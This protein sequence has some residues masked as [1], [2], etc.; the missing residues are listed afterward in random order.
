MSGTAPLVGDDVV[1]IDLFIRYGQWFAQRNVPDVENV[2]VTGLKQDGH[3]YLVTLATGEQ[4]STRRLC[5]P[6]G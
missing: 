1:P 6:P 3:R 5:S 2:K 4:I